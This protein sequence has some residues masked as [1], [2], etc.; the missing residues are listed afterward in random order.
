MDE[1]S[2]ELV[3]RWQG[4]DQQAAT[5]LFE[6]YAGQLI[7]L[8]RTRMTDKLAQRIDPEDVVQSAYRS[9]FRAVR[10]GRYLPAQG[11][12]IW[13]LLVAI[14]LRK[15][16]DQHDRHQADKRSMDRE[17]PLPELGG[18]FGVAPKIL[19]RD[20]SPVEAVVLAEELDQF[21]QGLEPLHCRILELWLEGCNRDEIAARIQ[22]SQRT[23]RRV[24]ETAQQQLEQRCRGLL[25]S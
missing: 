18:A 24:L 25:A 16:Y 10:A 4:G 1:P 21:L 20:P 5:A 3:A 6:R 12:R 14:T 9:F 8:A 17:Q 15:L 2:A 19:A 13:S 11:A 22:R 23:V 7:A